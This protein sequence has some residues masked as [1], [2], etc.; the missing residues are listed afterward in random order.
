[1]KMPDNQVAV[2]VVGLGSMGH[3]FALNLHEKGWPVSPW[4]LNPA[5]TKKTSE[6]VGVDPPRSLGHM[7]DDLP[8]PRRILMMLPAGGPVDDAID[9][10][11]PHLEEGDILIDGGNSLYEDSMRRSRKLKKRKIEF[12]GMGVSGGEAGARQGASLMPA[13]SEK[14]WDEIRPMLES[15]AARV[16]DEPCVAR[17]GTDGAGHFVKTVHNG[18]EYAT[19]QAVGEAYAIYR[20]LLGLSSD[21]IADRFEA[22]NEGPFE[23]YL[24]EMT[25]KVLRARDGNGGDASLVDVIVDQAEP[26]TTALWAV[27]AA[28]E[29]GVPLPSISAAVNARRIS[30]MRDHRELLSEVISPAP[31]QPEDGKTKDALSELV[32]DSLY[33]SIACVYVQ[34]FDLIRAAST[35]FHWELD[36]AEI[37]RIWR[38]G[39]VIR[40][41]LLR[42]FCD[43]CR[44]KPQATSLLLCRCVADL[45]RE[46]RGNWSRCIG[47]AQEHELSVPLFSASLSWYDGMRTQRLPQNLTQALRDACGSHGYERL[48]EPGVVHH[49][50]WE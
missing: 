48:D 32:I 15:I 50:G 4:D 42:I 7:I 35:R 26:R 45:I 44:E 43:T 11:L 47:I 29:L 27:E 41:E 24:L 17:T 5:R 14:A 10:L 37:A 1:M 23:S 25:A 39:C 3:A 36:L 34:G 20:D 40:S 6:E 9:I 38:G 30:F 8:K 19:V 49:G 33:A 28:L 31:K 21:E 2:G 46:R 12:V 13:C 18:I 16:D 22:A